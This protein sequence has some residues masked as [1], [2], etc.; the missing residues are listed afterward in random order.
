MASNAVH[1]PAE[2][3][4][5]ID[6]A[7]EIKGGYSNRAEYVRECVR[8]RSHNIVEESKSKTKKKIGKWP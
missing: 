3:V 4:E 8:Q 2:L 7:M 6:Q 5:L 1:F